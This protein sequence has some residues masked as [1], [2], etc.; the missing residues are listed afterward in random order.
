MMRPGSEPV[1][2][3]ESGWVAFTALSLVSLE[4][5]GEDHMVRL[6]ASVHRGQAAG[7]AGVRDKD[8]GQ[9]KDKS[10]GN[11][12]GQDMAE[13]KGP[14]KPCPPGQVEQLPADS[15]VKSFL[16][17]HDYLMEPTSKAT[18]TSRARSGVRHCALRPP[19]PSRA[20]PKASPSA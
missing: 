7:A 5:S 20:R 13:A 1:A 18:Y 6:L 8:S 11:G 17:E 3:R 15:G 10:Q 2:T 9:G 16:E 4:R 12:K 14:A 19:G